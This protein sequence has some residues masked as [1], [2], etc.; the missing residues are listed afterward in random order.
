M[1]T[2]VNLISVAGNIASVFTNRREIRRT[3]L[4]WPFYPVDPMPVVTKRSLYRA[5]SPFFIVEVF[6][7]PTRAAFSFPSKFYFGRSC[8]L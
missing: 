3:T 6:G 7:C 2:S 8:F 5:R 4:Y 1:N